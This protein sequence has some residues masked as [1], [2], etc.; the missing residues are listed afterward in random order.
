MKTICKSNKSL[1]DQKV[2]RGGTL[3]LLRVSGMLPRARSLSPT[4]AAP[5]AS[6]EGLK[7]RIEDS[8]DVRA[9]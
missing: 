8:R 3:G 5:R 4:S 2:L 6:A 1:I 9:G 7:S